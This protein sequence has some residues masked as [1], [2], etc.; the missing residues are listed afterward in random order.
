MYRAVSYC[1]FNSEKQLS[2]EGIYN[3]STNILV[4]KSVYTSIVMLFSYKSKLKY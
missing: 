3:Q 2:V 1:W 4:F